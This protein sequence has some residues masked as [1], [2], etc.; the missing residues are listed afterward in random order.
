[1]RNVAFIG[2]LATALAGCSSTTG[3]GQRDFSTAAAQGTTSAAHLPAAS[4]GFGKG[5][6]NGVTVTVIDPMTRDFH[7]SAI[8][9]AGETADAGQRDMSMAAAQ[10]ATS[11]AHLRAAA[12][13]GFGKGMFNG[14]AVTVID[15][16][17][18]D[19]H[20]SAA[21]AAGIVGNL[22][23]ESGGFVLYQELAPLAG[24]GGAGWA[25]WTGPRRRAFEAWANGRGL[26]LRSLEA[27]YGFLKQELET[28][29]KGAIS[30]V[31]L[32]ESVEAAMQAF[33]AA[34]ERSGIKHY[35]SRRKWAGRAYAAWIAVRT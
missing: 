13:S 19:F 10:G 30:A 2:L 15:R 7:L 9:A 31:K 24:R 5:M 16:L 32:A 23:H 14:I 33:E 26:D 22:A 27:N 11:A 25:Q 17:M 4:S 35:P 18:R 20:L 29:Y 6:F 28:G 1:M 3:G 21:Q 8:Q 34:Y 12:S